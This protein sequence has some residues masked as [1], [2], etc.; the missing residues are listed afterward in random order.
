[1]GDAG[2]RDVIKKVEREH[3]MATLEKTKWNRT[4]AAK[5]LGIDYKTLYNKMREHGIAERRV[6][7]RRRRPGLRGWV[8]VFHL[9]EAEQV[10]QAQMREGVPRNR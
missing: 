7:N 1:M 9:D 5:L 4:E 6:P 2:L 10:H 8:R 3:I